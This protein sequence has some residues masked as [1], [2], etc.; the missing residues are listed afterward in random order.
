MTLYNMVLATAAYFAVMFE[1][2]AGG[3]GIPEVKC[4]LNGLN[5]PRLVSIKTLVCKTIG[6]I[7]CSAGL[8]SW[9]RRAP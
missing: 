8:P 7:C 1:P 9:V 2:L 3:S 4:F 6:I 5:I